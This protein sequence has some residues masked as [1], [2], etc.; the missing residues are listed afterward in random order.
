L[1]CE[2]N[3]CHI[4]SFE[5]VGRRE[6]NK[7]DKQRG[8]EKRQ[9]VYSPFLANCATAYNIVNVNDARRK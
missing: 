8:L 4:A 6:F 7:L 5:P 3:E 1:T 9:A 2:F